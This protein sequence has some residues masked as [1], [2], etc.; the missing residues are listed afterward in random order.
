VF[1]EVLKDRTVLVLTYRHQAS[2]QA[3][4]EQLACWSM[5]AVYGV[6]LFFS[7]HQRCSACWEPVK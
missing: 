1:P 5:C 4:R 2:V 6:H 7:K 3:T